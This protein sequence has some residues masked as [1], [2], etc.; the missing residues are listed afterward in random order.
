MSSYKKYNFISP[1][2]SFRKMVK[3]ILSEAPEEAL[4]NLSNLTLQF[5]QNLQNMFQLLSEVSSDPIILES[6][7]KINEKYNRLASRYAELPKIA[8]TIS[9]ICE[10]RM[11]DEWVSIMSTS[12]SIFSRAF[13]EIPNIFDSFPLKFSQMQ[14]MFDT[15]ESETKEL[16]V[17][18]I[19]LKDLIFK[20]DDKKR[21][22]KRN[23]SQ[24][25]RVNAAI[26]LFIEKRLGEIY[27][28]GWGLKEF[29]DNLQVMFE[30]WRKLNGKAKNEFE[31][32]EIELHRE[33]IK[34][35][36]LYNCFIV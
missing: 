27:P 29:K 24:N 5:F 10:I 36:D 11:I 1:P 16:K 12:K 6:F 15:L 34:E 23:D 28:N 33:E 14:K 25:N 35:L 8:H 9:S 18:F 17:I 20:E 21:I 4:K 22:Y 32:L 30:E 3:T 7:N 13:P 26:I 2:Q 31:L 19:E